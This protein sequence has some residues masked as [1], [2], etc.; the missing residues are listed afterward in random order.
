MEKKFREFRMNIVLILFNLLFI[1]YAVIQLLDKN[2]MGVIAASS[3]I[4]I[5]L[6]LLLTRYKMILYKDMMIIYEWKILAML[7]SLVMYED[8]KSMEVKSKHHIIIHHKR[9][10]HIYVFNS[11]RFIETYEQM[12]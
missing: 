2:I 10:S 7:P 12:K 4:L 11:A 6:M 8:I 9:K 5:A 3:F 1:S